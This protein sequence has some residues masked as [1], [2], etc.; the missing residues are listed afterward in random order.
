MEGRLMKRCNECG[1]MNNKNETICYYC[2]T[3]L[4]VYKN[5][6]TCRSCGRDTD[7]LIQLHEMNICPICFGNSR[8]T[9]NY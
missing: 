6:L 1:A 4:Q 5:I 2:G 9:M 7:I 8:F 3:H